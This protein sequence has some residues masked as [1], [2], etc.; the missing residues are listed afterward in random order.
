MSVVMITPASVATSSRSELPSEVGGGIQHGH[1]RS[2][3]RS[4]FGKRDV[5]RN[6]I[7]TMESTIVHGFMP[8]FG[9][10][11]N[12]VRKSTLWWYYRDT[13]QDIIGTTLNTEIHDAY[14]TIKQSAIL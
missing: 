9:S 6:F 11:N 5:Q 3:Q 13:C 8:N 4:A 2:L 10:R 12:A 7:E 1:T 14:R